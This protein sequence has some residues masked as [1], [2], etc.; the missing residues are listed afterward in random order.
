MGDG[1]RFQIAEVH[2]CLAEGL[3][4]SSVMSLD[5]TVTLASTLDAIRAQLGTT[6]PGE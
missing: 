2:R 6:Y 5:E 4:E 1:L 3:T